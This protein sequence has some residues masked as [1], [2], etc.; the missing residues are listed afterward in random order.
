MSGKPVV[1]HPDGHDVGVT[2]P[3]KVLFPKDGITKSEV[4][5]YYRQISRWTLHIAGRP[6]AM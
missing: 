2:R 4:I 5:R 3:G 6:L 1:L